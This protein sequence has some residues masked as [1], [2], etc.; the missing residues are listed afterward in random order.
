VAVAPNWIVSGEVD[1]SAVMENEVG[2]LP[3]A[4]GRSA[5]LSVA[6]LAPDA[7]G[8]EAAELWPVAGPGDPVGF[9]GAL[10]P[11][12]I[13]RGLET[14]EPAAVEVE[15][16]ATAGAPA[17]PLAAKG[18]APEWETARKMAAPAATPIAAPKATRRVP[19]R[20]ER[21]KTPPNVVD[22]PTC[23]NLSFC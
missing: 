4:C 22:G 17:V 8:V 1:P 2:V 19:R 9:A 7:A 18:T 11:A 3:P 6:G 15:G 5:P 13:E 14:C 16:D 20:D 23:L 21:V 10:P 12:A